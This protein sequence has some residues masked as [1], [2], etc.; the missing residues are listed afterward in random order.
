MKDVVI[1][2]ISCVA[3]GVGVCA[4]VLVYRMMF[5]RPAERKRK[6]RQTAETNG[7]VTTAV[8]VSVK[9]LTH[10]VRDTRAQAGVNADRFEDET[11][12]DYR[13][14]VDGTIYTRR[15]VYG[16]A[17]NGWAAQDKGPVR[18]Y[19]ERDNPSNCLLES[20]WCGTDRG[21]IGCALMAVAF[22]VALAATMFVLGRLFGVMS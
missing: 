3:L 5:R 7:W 21:G 22:W 10:H 14:E 17:A 4:A 16:N 11:V 20:E 8:P 6:L 9:S 13:Y 1:A 18:V 2:M 12:V 19:Y 15:I